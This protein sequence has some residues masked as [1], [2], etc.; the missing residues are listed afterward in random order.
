MYAVCPPLHSLINRET[1][2]FAPAGKLKSLLNVFRFILWGKEQS[3]VMSYNC[4]M[5]AF[6]DE[7]R[8]G[9]DN[10]KYLCH[11]VWWVLSCWTGT[12]LWY[13]TKTYSIIANETSL[14]KLWLITEAFQEKKL[15]N[16]SKTLNYY[17]YRNI[18]N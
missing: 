11:C 9:P 8:I 10:G 15:T 16:E 2:Q 18:I 14:G 7:V 13:V 1:A 17:L 6:T 4:S 3:L 12:V 5:L